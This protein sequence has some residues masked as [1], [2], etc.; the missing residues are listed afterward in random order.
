M[1]DAVRVIRRQLRAFPKRKIFRKGRA[2]LLALVVEIEVLRKVV[3]DMQ[4]S[5]A[6]NVKNQQNEDEANG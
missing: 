3:A 4:S 2:T 6:D 1:T 5:V